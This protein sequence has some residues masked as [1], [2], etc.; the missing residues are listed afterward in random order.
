METKSQIL[1]LI[2]LVNIKR[3]HINIQKNFLE[4]ELLLKLGQ[5]V[6][7]Q[8]KQHS[9]YV[10]KYYEERGIPVNNAEVLRIASGCTGIKR[11]TGQHPGGIIVV[12]KGR[13]IYEFTP[14]QHPADDPN[15]D[16]IT[17]HFDYHSIDQNLLKLDI[18]GHDDPTIIRMLQD[19]KTTLLIWITV[20]HILPYLHSRQVF[21]SSPIQI[22]S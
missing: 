13:E 5:L 20:C 2:S 10:K 21:F 17:T 6:L 4:K 18:L 12:P 16:I 3:K 8:I 14:V 9:G 22:V 15:S 19:I 7:L 1:I 11:T